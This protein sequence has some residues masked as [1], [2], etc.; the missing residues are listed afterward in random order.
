MKHGQS[1]SSYSI[2]C[3]H[4]KRYAKMQKEIEEACRDVRGVSP[5]DLQEGYGPVSQSTVPSKAN[6][7]FVSDFL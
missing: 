4:R 5:E 7:K 1:E 2:F 6:V 3:L